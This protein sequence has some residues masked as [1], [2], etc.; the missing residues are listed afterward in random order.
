MIDIPE[1]FCFRID[2]QYPRKNLFKKER[3]LRNYA[4]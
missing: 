1:E 4:S 3:I 2:I